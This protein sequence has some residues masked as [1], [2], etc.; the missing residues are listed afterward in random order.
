MKTTFAVL[1]LIL[2]AAHLPTTWL[3]PDP[4]SPAT[5]VPVDQGRGEDCPYPPRC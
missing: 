3:V 4:T 2:G 1:A 5:V